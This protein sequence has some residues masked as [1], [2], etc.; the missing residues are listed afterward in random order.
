MLDLDGNGKISKN[1]LKKVL[2]SDPTFSAKNDTYWESMIK[3]VDKNNDGEIDW[4]EFNDMMNQ[5]SYKKSD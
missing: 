3:E 2:G 1:E 4:D 5:I